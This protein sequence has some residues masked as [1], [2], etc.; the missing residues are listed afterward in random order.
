MPVDPLD[1]PHIA[2]LLPWITKANAAIDSK[3]EDVRAHAERSLTRS[4]IDAA[5]GRSTWRMLKGQASAKA[6]QKRLSGL[7]EYLVGNTE[8]SLSG[9]IQTARSRFYRDSFTHWHSQSEPFKSAFDPDAKPVASG[10]LQA[11]GVIFWGLSPRKELEPLFLTVSNTLKTSMN[12]AATP[13]TS[14][15]QQDAIFGGWEQKAKKRIK[16]EVE[17]LLS[18]SQIAIITM[19]GRDMVK[20]E[21][22]A[23]KR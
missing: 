3:I 7:L 8:A 14:E 1:A 12:A 13:G 11:R 22:R 23:E 21:F 19:V 20:A 6:A 18:N 9:L 5:E 15:K 10:E 16:H 17:G 2:K 4:V